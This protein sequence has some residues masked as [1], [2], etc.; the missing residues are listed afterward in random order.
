MPY[1][2]LKHANH[3]YEPYY[4]YQPFSQEEWNAYPFASEEDLQW[5]RDA[6]LGLFLHVG[7]SA[8]GKVD[9]G[10]SR[11]TH[12][13]PD[14]GIGPVADEI[15]DHWAEEISLP[16]FHAREWIQLA[17][18]GGMQY[19]VIIT[20]H[21][22]GFHMWDTAYSDYK[23]TNTPFGRD[24]LRELVDA[25]HEMGMKVGLYY[26]Q[27]DWKHPDY[28]PIPPEV[29]Q[30]ISPHE[31]FQYPEGYPIRIS[32]K[33]RRYIAYLHNTVREL[34]TNYGKIDILWWDASWWG[35]MFLEEM[36]D[37]DAIE[38]EARRLQPHLLINNRA[39]LPGDF[40][41]PEGDIGFF[42]NSRPWETC[43]PLGTAW[44]WTGEE[45]KPFRTVLHQ[46]INCICGDGNYLLSIGT[47]PSGQFDLPE[48]Q[49][50]RQLG[51]WLAQYGKSVYGTRGGPWLPGEWGGATFVDSTV[52]LH[53]LNVK[54]GELLE[55]PSIAARILRTDC[56]TGETVSVLQEKTG[57]QVRIAAGQVP[58]DDVIV[59]LELDRVPEVLAPTQAKDSFSAA[60]VTYGGLVLEQ[61]LEIAGSKTFPIDASSLLTGVVLQTSG[62][63]TL[64]VEAREAAGG[65]MELA[66]DRNGEEI[67]EIPVLRYEAG[68]YIAGCRCEAL[69]MRVSAPCR[70]T[71]RVYAKKA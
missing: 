56:L 44:A 19:V 15:Y 63:V 30:K 69:R 70:M 62:N 50:I 47:M 1:S 51:R 9:I 11:R 65:W 34:M 40:D 37:A 25:C 66:N 64:S 20:K 4:L 12:K 59:Q 46:F 3:N 28:E 55:L 49:R 43:M 38:R 8:L 68:A 35:R 24:Y 71:V 67:I 33:H 17:K 36:W 14:G 41:T 52:Y 23:I 42:Q 26:S 31:L 57:V 58:G 54:A 6:K 2:V 5:F 53:L 29:A 7:I 39:S 45:I 32:D 27:R 61:E 60:P 48:Q 10:W 21:H 16:D 22:D 13:L 18:D